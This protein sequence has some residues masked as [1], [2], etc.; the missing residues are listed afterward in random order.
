MRPRATLRPRLDVGT[1]KTH[2]RPPRFPSALGLRVNSLLE[3]AIQSLLI[4]IEDYQANDPRR[5]LSA[6]RNFY[7]ATLRR[8]GAGVAATWATPALPL[9]TWVVGESGCGVVFRGS[10]PSPA[11]GACL[12]AWRRCRV[13][14]LPHLVDAERQRHQ[15]GEHRSLPDQAGPV[16]RFTSRKLLSSFIPPV[17]LP[18][19]LCSRFTNIDSAFIR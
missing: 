14:R 13:R 4:G 11:S 17:V 12:D 6:V 5:A 10:G 3:N 16:T 18:K 9:A 1:D 2:R 8:L 7:A 15:T 19:Q